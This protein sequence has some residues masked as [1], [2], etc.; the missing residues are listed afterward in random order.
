MDRQTKLNQQKQPAIVSCLTVAAVLLNGF[1]MAVQPLNAQDTS[2]ENPEKLQI[3]IVRGANLVNSVKRRVATEPIVEV[4]DRNKKPVG[5]V[6]LT[7]TLPDTGPSGTFVST[8]SRLATVATG[9]DGRA[10]MPPFQSN[11]VQGSF[12]IHVSGTHEGVSFDT[13]IN[14]ENVAG[15]TGGFAHATAFKV[16]IFVAAGAAVGATVAATRGGGNSKTT[17]TPG[18]PTVTGASI[19]IRH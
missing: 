10:V 12:N 14:V 15:A 1:V 4:R 8:G 18:T 2:S 16:L 6:I 17:V 13:T 3:T 5:G 19:G 9:P 7:F 11:E